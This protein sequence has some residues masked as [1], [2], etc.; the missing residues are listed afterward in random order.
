MQAVKKEREQCLRTVEYMHQ[1]L[2]A[3]ISGSTV[4]ELA[5]TPEMLDLTAKT[6]KCVALVTSSTR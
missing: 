6:A 4:D 3:L 1:L 5:L 2:A